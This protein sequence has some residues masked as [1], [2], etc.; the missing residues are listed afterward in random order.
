MDD[1]AQRRFLQMRSV[2][3]SRQGAHDEVV[4]Q[5]ARIRVEAPA[6][7][8]QWDS[9]VRVGL[10][11]GG[12]LE[13]TFADL[14]A[15]ARSFGASLR[16]RHLLE[17]QNPF[18]PYM[19]DIATSSPAIELKIEVAGAQ[20]AIKGPG[21]VA[22]VEDDLTADVLSHRASVVEH[23]SGDL[24]VA[25]R[26]FRAY[27]Q[28][29]LSVVEAFIA[30][31]VAILEHHKQPEAAAALQQVSLDARFEAWAALFSKDCG[32]LRDGPEWSQFSELRSERN[33]IV[34]AVH[35]VVGYRVADMARYLNYVR[36]GIG[37]LL[38]KMRE[39]EGLASLSFIERLRSAPE[40]T[41]E[42]GV[43]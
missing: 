30:R 26:Y 23:A 2:H 29:A 21:R 10:A 34:H 25:T 18:F 36:V 8:W 19:A 40:I 1:H 32:Q 42:S 41:V 39:L 15:E 16:L 33:R 43:S 20:H 24:R 13:A 14:L 17:A 35:P 7:G 37:G 12:A 22:L 27:L 11:D 9:R 38:R 4:D 3:L 5:L 28:S 31:H 6:S